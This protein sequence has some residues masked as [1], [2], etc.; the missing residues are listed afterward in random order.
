M[1]PISKKPFKTSLNIFPEACYKK[2]RVGAGI[3]N[4]SPTYFPAD[5]WIISIK[6]NITAILLLGA[7]LKYQYKRQDI[8]TRD[9]FFRHVEFVPTL[10]E[11]GKAMFS[12][13]NFASYFARKVAKEDRTLTN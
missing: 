1:T 13:K 12:I 3:T 10:T 5:P 9:I 2:K 4:A 11:S 6:D 7:S 8:A